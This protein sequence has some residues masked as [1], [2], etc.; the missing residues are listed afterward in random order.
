MAEKGDCD[1]VQVRAVDSGGDSTNCRHQR[2]WYVAVVAGTVVTVVVADVV[3]VNAAAAV[4]NVVVVLT[5]AAAV[6][7]AVVVVNATAA[8]MSV[9]VVTAAAVR[10]YQATRIR[11]TPVDRRDVDWPGACGKM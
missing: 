7:S 6:K 10:E 11:P 2:V 1:R 5:A 4:K 8:A 3:A 9:V